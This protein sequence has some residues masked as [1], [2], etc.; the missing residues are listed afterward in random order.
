MKSKTRFLI[1]IN[2]ILDLCFTLQFTVIIFI[3][4][5]ELVNFVVLHWFKKQTLNINFLQMKEIVYERE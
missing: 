5:S 3:L 4:F 1:T 2:I